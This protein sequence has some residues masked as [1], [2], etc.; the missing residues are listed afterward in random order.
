MAKFRKKLKSKGKRWVKGQSSVTN[1]DSKK[2]RSQAHMNFCKPIFGK[3][4]TFY[5]NNNN[6][7]QYFAQLQELKMKEKVC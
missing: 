2:Y 1:P 7:K 4:L 3:Y 6:L 5:M